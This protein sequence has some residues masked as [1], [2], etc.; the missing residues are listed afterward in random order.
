MFVCAFIDEVMICSKECN[1]IGSLSFAVL[2]MYLCGLVSSG[3]EI[4]FFHISIIKV[5]ESLLPSSPPPFFL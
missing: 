3:G 2:T 5:S 1:G 4:V